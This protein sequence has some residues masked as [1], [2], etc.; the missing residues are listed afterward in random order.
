MSRAADGQVGQRGILRL[1]GVFFAFMGN[2][3]AAL[4]L[5]CSMGISL[6]IWGM[7]FY[8]AG[9]NTILN[10]KEQEI[11]ANSRCT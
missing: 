11:Y 9:Q 5:I 8:L 2:P 1:S 7:L 4:G 3:W 10:D 6:A